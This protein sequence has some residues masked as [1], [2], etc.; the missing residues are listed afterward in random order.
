MSNLQQE[1]D[2]TNQKT[3]CYIYTSKLS[4]FI[5]IHEFQSTDGVK[6]LNT[7]GKCLSR[8]VFFICF[9]VCQKTEMACS[10]VKFNLIRL[11]ISR[12]SPQINSSAFSVCQN[13]SRQSYSSHWTEQENRVVVAD[14]GST[15]VCWHPEPK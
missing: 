4:P 15:I 1:S 9:F 14:N 5:E 3:F 8:D 6:T 7:E 10:L 2:F 11:S 13:V 12:L